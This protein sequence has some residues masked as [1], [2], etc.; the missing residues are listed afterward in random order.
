MVRRVHNGRASWTRCLAKAIEALVR[1][2]RACTVLPVA[3]VLL[4]S[5]AGASIP[6]QFDRL[7]LDDG[8]SQQNVKVIAQDP[9]GFMWLGTEDGLN[10]YDGYTFQHIRHERGNSASLPNNYINDVA[11][12]AA[13]NLWVATAGGGVARRD[14]L[15]G[16]FMVVAFDSGAAHES[17][18]SVRVIRFDHTGRLWIGTVA[19]G[20]AVYDPTSGA[21]RRFHPSRL[22]SSTR[23]D[24]AI[25]ALLEDH[26]GRIWI[27]TGA[28]VCVLEPTSG[29]LERYTLELARDLPES[30]LPVQSLLED[31]LGTIWIAT[32]HGLEGIDARTHVAQTFRPDAHDMGALPAP[33]V[34]ALFEDHQQRLWVGTAQG[35]ALFDRARRAFL[36]YRFDATDRASLP[37]DNVVSLFEDRGGLLWVGTKAGVAKWNPRTWLFGHRRAGAEDAMAS[38]Y[39]NGFTEDLA[40]RLWIATFGGGLAVVERR[41]DQTRLLRHEEGNPESLS[42]DRV[43][44]LLTDHTGSV[45]AGTMDGGLN[46]IDPDSLHVT[47]YRHDPLDARSLGAPGVM[48]L[49]EDSK[50]GIWVG[51]HGGGISRF[52]RESGT[53]QHYLSPGD[54]V[55]ALVEDTRGRIWAGTDGRGLQVLDPQSG[56]VVTLR[57]DPHDP[58]TLSGDTVYALHVDAHGTVWIGTRDSG[59]DRAIETSGT[60]AAIRFANL[61]EANGLPNN[62]VYGIESDVRGRLW[63]STN[64]GLACL[65]PGTGRVRDFHRAQGL[66]AEEF[67][68]GAHYRSRTGE[69]LIGG[70]NG[71]NRFDPERLQLNDI[72]PPIALTGL[73]EL[74]KPASTSRLYDRLSQLHLGYRD[75]IVTFE[76]AALDYT[77][78]AAN[79]FQYQLVGFDRTWVDAGTRRSVTYTRLAGG[80]YTL[81]VRAANADGVWNEKGW[82][83]ALHVD[84]PPW[85]TGWAYAGY[86]LLALLAL[87]GTWV[88]HRRSLQREE[89]HAR[90]LEQQV[91]L[92]TQQLD[93]RNRELVQTNSRLEQANRMLEE[94]SLTD[95]LTGLGNRRSLHQA[96]PGLIAAVDAQNQ[97]GTRRETRLA[98][99]LVD[100][101]RLK[102]INDQHGHEAG[103]Q[104]LSQVSAILKECVR[105]QDK[106]VRWG[107]DEFVIAHIT[108]GLDGAAALAER[109]RSSVSKKRFRICAEQFART[110]VSI[111][112]ACYPFVTAAPHAIDWEQ[113]LNLADTALYRAKV[114]RNAWVGWSGTRA[115]ATLSDLVDR[116][117]IDASAAER[118]GYIEA[119]AS[120]P[121]LDDT[122]ELLLRRPVANA[123]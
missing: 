113:A 92:R 81:R 116:L 51:T 5:A 66:Q 99:M 96:M 114:S 1:A 46:R 62:T 44:A 40:G 48:S 76:F 27:G 109:I 121:A 31:H 20:V 13:G 63:L 17:L 56:Q 25:F 11:L 30:R 4:C 55:T 98:L 123:R 89:A 14:P 8:L 24:D 54:R 9:S 26:S 101:D 68:F 16:R 103:D 80:D 45:W 7:G 108:D 34:N 84:P 38:R 36:T 71:Y 111:G 97:H 67:N 50:G 107:G 35:L 85:K 104:V 122:V 83:L 78:P 110:S 2:A 21:L 72:A 90:Q 117:E 105:A 93:E 12:D 28:G 29:R 88:G 15:T 60:A 118:D 23:D 102:P 37:D 70:A 82:A 73:F 49:L 61:S 112:F 47:A 79:V 39:I 6:M 18:T 95:V 19:E 100:L 32:T 59:L 33:V 86:G 120:T 65:D 75:E 64:H 58:L 94:V 115:A 74:N 10:R 53:F 41:T 52:E 91:R 3:C 69:M 22:L 87:W 119:R 43:M 42:D 77:A 57:H 106:V